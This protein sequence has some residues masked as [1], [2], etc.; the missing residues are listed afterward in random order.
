MHLTNITNKQYQIIHLLYRFRFL[1]R[2]QIQHLLQHKNHR[3]IISWLTD[4]TDKNYIGKQEHDSQVLR[5]PSVYYIV[6]K[7][8]QQ[9]RAH[10]ECDK[11]NLNKLYKEHIKSG[12]F[13]NLHLSIADIFL[14]LNDKYTDTLVFFT[15]ADFTKDSIIREISPHFT[16]KRKESESYFIGELFL[17]KMPYFAVRNRIDEYI[18]FFQTFDWLKY[19]K[20][21]KLLF[22]CPNKKIEAYVLHFTQRRFQEENIEIDVFITTKE[23]VKKCGVENE[24]WTQIKTS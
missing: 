7:S 16:Y 15:R 12:E 3:R 19:D 4:L 17:D 11:N 21:P 20:L 8:I 23:N 5:K 22:I 1:N 2:I 6:R 13:I 9:L 18:S 24:I 14:S 10:S